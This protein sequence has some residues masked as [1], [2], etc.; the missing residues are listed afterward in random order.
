[1]KRILTFFLFLS[2]SF[3]FGQNPNNFP[4]VN[5]PTH[6][7]TTIRVYNDEGILL[8]E[9]NYVNG[10]PLGDYKYYYTNG[11]LMEEGKWDHGHQVGILKRYDKNGNICQFFNFDDRG[12]RVGN[13]LYYYSSG[14]IRA[15]K[16][17][18][19]ENKPVNIIRFNSEGK[20][21]S[22]ITL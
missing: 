3:L 14:T 15:K 11:Q 19:V 5:D 10:R 12:N 20:Q 21:K 6:T 8:S 13:Q 7:F 9:I 4:F 2:I 16:L 17:L 22:Y 18:D 1:M